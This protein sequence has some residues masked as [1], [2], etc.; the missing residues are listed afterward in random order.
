M[1]QNLDSYKA[2]ADKAEEDKMDLAHELKVVGT[3]RRLPLSPFFFP[4][5][6]GCL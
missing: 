1:R 4:F 6:F 2:L 5:C 3:K